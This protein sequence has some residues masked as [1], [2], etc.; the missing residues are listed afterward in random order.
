[1][2]HSFL[3]QEEKV[4]LSLY[5]AMEASKAED[6]LQY[7]TTI[8]CTVLVVVKYISSVNSLPVFISRNLP[9][10]CKTIGKVSLCFTNYALRHEG[11]WESGCIDPHFVDLGTSW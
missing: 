1:M 5:Q 2:P 4:K 9:L 11:L 3:I 7:K 10:L 6:T 8:S